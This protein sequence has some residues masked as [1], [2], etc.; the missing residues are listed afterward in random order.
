MSGSIRVV[1][2]KKGRKRKEGRKGKQALPQ[3]VYSKLD[4]SK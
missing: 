3:S 4:K 1:K 2:R